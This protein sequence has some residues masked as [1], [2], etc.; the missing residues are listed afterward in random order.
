MS[1]EGDARPGDEEGDS[2]RETKTWRGNIKGLE[3]AVNQEFVFLY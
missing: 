2:D 1:E 3:G